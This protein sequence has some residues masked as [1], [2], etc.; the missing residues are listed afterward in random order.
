[1]LENCVGDSCL[2]GVQEYN[3]RAEGHQPL[4]L[5]FVHFLS[6][7]IWIH[8]TRFNECSYIWDLI[9]KQIQLELIGISKWNR[10]KH[11]RGDVRSIRTR[12]V[13]IPITTNPVQT[14]PKTPFTREGNRS[15]S[16]RI[17]P[18]S[19]AL[20]G[21]VYAEI[22]RIEP[23]RSIKWN[24]QKVIRKVERCTLYLFRYRLNRQMEIM[25]AERLR[26]RLHTKQ[27]WYAIVRFQS[28]Q[29]ICPFQTLEGKWNGT[30]AFPCE[31]GLRQALVAGSK[32]IHYL[33]SCVEVTLNFY[34]FL[35]IIDSVTDT[36]SV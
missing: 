34:I 18:K 8:S 20:N 17:F 33:C 12:N 19:G 24:D 11:P 28:E 35:K 32:C 6:R 31:L 2:A 26:S 25:S 27:N 4:S 22:R 7:L 23:L 1:M 21:C 13:T 29:H 16:F 15:T 3:R 36:G 9:R 10:F 30:N 5:N 14:L